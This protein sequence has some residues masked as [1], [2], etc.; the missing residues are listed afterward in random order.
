MREAICKLAMALPH[1]VSSSSSSIHPFAYKIPLISHPIL[2]IYH[3]SH[4]I[5]ENSQPQPPTKLN[6]LRQRPHPRINRIPLL[7]Q[8]LTL[9]IQIPQWMRK[10]FNE[11]ILFQLCLQILIDSESGI[12]IDV[13]ESEIRVAESGI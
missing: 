8:P 12:D 9:R 6:P 2:S 13:H 4:H 11:F 5:T 10:H 1:V 3:V 7:F